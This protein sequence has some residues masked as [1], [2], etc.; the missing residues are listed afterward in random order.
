MAV[1][2]E[3]S[4]LGWIA[5]E[6]YFRYD[7]C[8][9]CKILGLTYKKTTTGSM[10][11]ATVYL[12]NIGMT[13]PVVLSTVQAYAEYTDNVNNIRSQG[14]VDYIGRTWYI[15]AFSGWQQ[16]DQR[17]TSGNS[18]KLT[19]DSPNLYDIGVAVLDAA[20]VTRKPRDPTQKKSFHIEYTGTS[21]VIRRLCERINNV[22]L[23]GVEHN[24]AFYGD[25]GNEA[26]L[27]SQKESGNPHHVTLEDLGIENIPRQ[28]QMVLESIGA[29]DSWIDYNLD[30]GD[31]IYFA[32][33]DD[34]ML[35]FRSTSN[36]LAWH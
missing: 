17:D 27:H 25:L 36:L 28:M 8:D 31:Y 34:D 18:H 13:G 14:T 9:L 4:G 35:V 12:P 22:A 16:G 6:E 30:Q 19:V 26:Y 10:V 5:D 11:Y 3:D 32:D 1:I 20:S 23:L 15:T 29:V 24:E 2:Y 21:K 7:P 33:H